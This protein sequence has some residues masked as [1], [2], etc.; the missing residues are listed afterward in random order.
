[1]GYPVGKGPQIRFLMNAE[2]T[3]FNLKSRENKLSNQLFPIR[4]PLCLH[5]FLFLSNLTMK[6]LSFSIAYG[7]KKISLFFISIFNELRLRTLSKY[8]ILFRFLNSLHF[9]LR[10]KHFLMPAIQMLL[11]IRFNQSFCFYK[12]I[13]LYYFYDINKFNFEYLS[14]LLC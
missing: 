8:T 7:T 1:M 11:L 2:S 5:F 10:L 4:I 12:F 13:L 14:K 6:S 3:L 9:N